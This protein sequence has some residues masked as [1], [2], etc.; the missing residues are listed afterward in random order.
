MNKSNFQ[1]FLFL[2]SFSLTVSLFAQKTDYLVIPPFQQVPDRLPQ[3]PLKTG[4]MIYSDNLVS[5]AQENILR[6]PAAK[7][8]KE[9]LIKA[10]DKMLTYTDEELTVLMSDARVPRAFDICVKGCPVHGDI[11]FKIGGGYPW[12]IDMEHPFQV[13][14]PVDGQ[15]FPSNDYAAYYKSGFKDKKDWD[16][17]YTDDG[18][19]WQSSDGERYWFVA[20][21]NHWIWY[22]HLLPGMLNLART[23]L[24]TDDSRYASKAV[25]ML[26][27]MAMI[28]PSMNHEEQSRY[29]LMMKSHGEQYA[30]KIL[31]RIWETIVIGMAAEAYDLVWKTI[32]TDLSLQ[33]RTGKTGEELRAFIEANLL[34]D[35]LDAFENNKIMGNYGMHQNAMITVQLSRQFAGME[36]VI[37]KILYEPSSQM[38]KN[39]VNYTIYNMIFRDGIPFESPGYNALWINSLIQIEEKLPAR[40]KD[41]FTGYRFKQILDAPLNMAAIGKYTP[42]IG[43]SG[44]VLGGLQARFSS[45][46]QAYDLFQDPRYLPWSNLSGEKS[47]NSFQSLFRRPLPD[48]HA[49]KGDRAVDVQPSRLFAGYGFGILNNKTD[50]TAIAFTYGKHYSHDHWDYLNIEVFAS[51]QKMMPDLGYPDAMNSFVSEIHTWSMNTVSHNTVVV[52]QKSQE[53]KLPGVLHD[54]ADGGFARTMDASSPAYKNTSE[55]RRNVIMVDTENGQSYFVDFFNV[56][57]GSRH[58]YS[59]HGPP[60]KTYCTDGEWSEVFPG[61]FAGPNVEMGYLYDDERLR[62]QGSEIGYTEYKGSG[63]QHLFHVQK[64]KSGKGILEYRHVIDEDARLRIFPLPSQ[65]QEIFIADAYDKPRAKENIIKY[66]I[67]TNKTAR[68]TPLKST[69]VSVLEPY[70]GEKHILADTRLTNPDAGNGHIVVVERDNDTDIIIYDPSGSTKKINRYRLNTDAVSA[71]VT[72]DKSGKLTRVFFSCGSYLYCQGKRFTARPVRGKVIAVDAL[73]RTFRVKIEGLCIAPAKGLSGQIAH[74]TNTFRTTVHPLSS[75]DVTGRMFDVKVKDDLLIGYFS[76]DKVDGS[77]WTTETYLPFYE[78]YT[79]TTILD[80][81]YR[82]SAILIKMDKGRLKIKAPAAIPL[83]P[84]DDAWLCN[85]NIG[86]QFLIKPVFS[87]EKPVKK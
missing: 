85:I 70:R 2:F 75:V 47:F 10:A 53:R 23:Y 27:L 35:A 32:D 46:H 77:E 28:Y 34:E 13:K 31:N 76:V 41:I 30:G 3:F 33:K 21:A 78:Y 8:I 26:Y 7:A 11:V 63:F 57:G 40:Y 19:G 61:T 59:L 16:T 22:D 24:L 9:N 54:F 84:G 79:G 68:D 52:D 71:V 74:F 62:R 36:N 14:C 64:L 4:S 12:I 66:M 39:G 1:F 86:D 56:C 49:L 5:L 42:D 69:F 65:G 38:F 15:V 29:G 58:D 55:Y 44:T 25:F 43:D 80:N 20:Y 17:E 18:W 72:F 60:G 82:P 45:Y 83:K 48:F 81:N 50:E 87:W 73:Q 37:Q 51:E 67:C 6:Y